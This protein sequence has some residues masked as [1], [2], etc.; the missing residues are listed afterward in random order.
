M[1]QHVRRIE[2]DNDIEYGLFFADGTA[3]DDTV[4]YPSIEA[5]ENDRKW[6]QLDISKELHVESWPVKKQL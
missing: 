3:L 4:T 5:A 1:T 6:E 2:F